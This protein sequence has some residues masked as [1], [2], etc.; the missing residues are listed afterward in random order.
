MANSTAIPRAEAGKLALLRNL[1]ATL[2]G[3]PPR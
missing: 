1:D 3:W 2:P